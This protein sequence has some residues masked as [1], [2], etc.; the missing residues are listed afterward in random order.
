[1]GGDSDGE[2]E[3]LSA[4]TSIEQRNGPEF[5]MRYK[6]HRCA[7]INATAARGF[8]SAQAMKALEEGYTQTMPPGMGFDY[9]GMSFQEQKTQQGVSPFAIFGL[10][11]LFAILIL[12]ALVPVYYY[13]L[14]TYQ[15]TLS[16]FGRSGYIFNQ[17]IHAYVDAGSNVQFTFIAAD[18]EGV[19]TVSGYL[20][21]CAGACP[22][23]P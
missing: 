13:F 8:S 20:V 19:V 3:R 10:S 17:P 2:S 9:L 23:E 5:T 1:M 14:A 21:D 4:V 16:F 7:Q 18:G 12:A 15:G 11:I 22:V 6:L